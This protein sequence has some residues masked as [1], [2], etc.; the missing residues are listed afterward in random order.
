M[1]ENSD[2]D[3]KSNHFT[4]QRVMA[5]LKNKSLTKDRIDF[6]K[7]LEHEMNVFLEF[8]GNTCVYVIIKYTKWKTQTRVRMVLVLE[9]ICR[10]IDVIFWILCYSIMK[11][12]IVTYNIYVMLL[13]NDN[14]Q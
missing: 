10:S 13:I 1:G 14:I 5:Y 11:D 12:I 9:M 6:G 4:Q 3:M 7:T 2:Y 8:I